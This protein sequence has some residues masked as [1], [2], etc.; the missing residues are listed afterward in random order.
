MQMC[1]QKIPKTYNSKMSLR[2]WIEIFIE[3]D[4]VNDTKKPK[5]IK[6]E[7]STL[8]AVGIVSENRKLYLRKLAHRLGVN[9]IKL[10][11]S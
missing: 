2:K 9:E 7:V 5:N 8:S 3:T 1:G 11:L 4:S 6:D 10:Y